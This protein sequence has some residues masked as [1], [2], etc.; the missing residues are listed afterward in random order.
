MKAKEKMVAVTTSVKA[1]NAAIVRGMDTITLQDR[2]ELLP[3][4]QT[5]Y[6]LASAIKELQATLKE[7]RKF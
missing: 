4:A 6:E 3:D 2:M 5:R 1:A 7:L